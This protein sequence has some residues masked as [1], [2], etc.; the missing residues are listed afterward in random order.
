MLYMH[1]YASVGSIP[2]LA[3]DLE[4]PPGHFLLN[5]YVRPEHDNAGLVRRRSALALGPQP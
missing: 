3:R 2:S 1:G 5:D 4:F